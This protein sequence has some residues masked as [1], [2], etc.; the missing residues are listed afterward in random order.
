MP[1]MHVEIA[2]ATAS[3]RVNMACVG[4]LLFICVRAIVRF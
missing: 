3:Y 1:V 4:V 2:S